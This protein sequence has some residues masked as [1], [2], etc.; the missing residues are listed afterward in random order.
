MG[1]GIQVG[2]QG[3]AIVV[4]LWGR[5]D[6]SALEPLSAAIRA[7]ASEGRQVVV[8]LDGVAGLHAGGLAAFLNE[9][10]WAVDRVSFTRH[11]DLG[12]RVTEVGS[13]QVHA[14]GSGAHDIENNPGG[15]GSDPGSPS[16]NPADDEQESQSGGDLGRLRDMFA[17]LET[18]Y[19]DAIS[20]CR[21][22]LASAERDDRQDA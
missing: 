17:Q 6:I 13:G 16:A 20:S 1:L 19:R 9:L 3:E 8:Y 18:Q 14:H 5:T 7:A 22:L 10:G 4:R 15:R 2:E 21:Q 11:P 12:A